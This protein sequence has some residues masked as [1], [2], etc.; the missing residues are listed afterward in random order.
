M[1]Y[2]E[3]LFPSL[4]LVGREKG[5]RGGGGGGL[6]RERKPGHL[7]GPSLETFGFPDR[8]FNRC[9]TGTQCTSSFPN[10]YLFKGGLYHLLPKFEHIFVAVITFFPLSSVQI[11]LLP[12]CC[13]LCVL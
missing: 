7:H 6:S 3:P 5:R 10:W 11:L 13:L 4:F 1:K 2:I 8:V 9:A 12:A